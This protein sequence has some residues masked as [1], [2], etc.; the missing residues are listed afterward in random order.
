MKQLSLFSGCMIGF[1]AGLCAPA[2]AS[3]V[4]PGVLIPTQ[5]LMG[6]LH[7]DLLTLRD[8]VGPDNQRFDV[9]FNVSS[10]NIS[11]SIAADTPI[12][13]GRVGLNAT[14]T[15]QDELTWT[16]TT[17]FG[18]LRASSA[19]TYMVTAEVNGNI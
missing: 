3:V 18:V 2:P 16:G 17:Q 4:E 9:G 14:V 19:K 13:D 10:G 15:R 11:Y 5:I 6:L 7:H 1:A 8:L 12:G